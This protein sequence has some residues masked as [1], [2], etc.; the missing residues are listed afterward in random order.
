MVS[1]V[2]YAGPCGL[3][4]YLWPGVLGVEIRLGTPGVAVVSCC[5]FPSW[6]RVLC[7]VPPWFGGGFALATFWLAYASLV[8]FQ[9]LSP[10][11]DSAHENVRSISV[12]PDCVSGCVA[13]STLPPSLGSIFPIYEIGIT[14]I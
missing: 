9:K 12:N 3:V 7:G 14:K 4:W 5:C 11:E 8:R 2:R 13:L 1:S 10:T 6:M